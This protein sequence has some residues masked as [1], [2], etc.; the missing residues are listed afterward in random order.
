MEINPS[1]YAFFIDPLLAS[2]FTRISHL[3]PEGSTVLDI[4]CGTGALVEQLAAK[5]ENATGIDID[6]QMIR[7]AKNRQ[8]SKNT[9]F[10]LSDARKLDLFSDKQFDFVIMSLAWHQFR[11]EERQI[12]LNEAKRVGKNIII[13]DYAC[14]GPKGVK[15]ILVKTAERMAGREHYRN[16]RSYM[17]EGGLVR[18]PENYNAKPG[19]LETSHSGI[20][21]LMKIEGV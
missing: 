7:Y 16:F 19:I 5:C 18:L 9:T 8:Q 11:P 3:I 20:F 13:S 14:P 15:K 21:A 12:I 6:L 10:H 1:V 4:A 2:S 17:N